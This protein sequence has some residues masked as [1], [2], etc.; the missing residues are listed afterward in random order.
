MKQKK[1]FQYGLALVIAAAVVLLLS[2]K[3]II[4]A[5]PQ[6]FGYRSKDLFGIYTA[7]LDGRGFTQILC[8]PTRELTHARFSP[9]GRRITMTRFNKLLVGGLAE[10]N[11]SGYVNTEVLV[12]NA[13][14]S[15]LRSL[16]KTGPDVMN[17]NSS[18]IDNDRLIF[19]HS[20]NIKTTLPELRIINLSTGSI[21]RVPT[22]KNSVASDP[23]TCNGLVVFPVIAL[24]NDSRV[25]NPLWLMHLDGKGLEQLTAPK[26]TATS[27]QLDFKL[28]DYDPWFAPDGKTVAFMRY[29]GGFDWRI[30]TVDTTTKKERELTLPGVGNGIPKWS[31]D[32]RLIVYVSWDHSKLENLGLYVMNAD[33]GNKRQLPLPA[34][35]LYTHPSFLP[36]SGSA[37]TARII[38]S[39]RHVPALPGSKPVN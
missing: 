29:F 19:I 27:N 20:P 1:V 31:S 7:Q 18:W 2:F 26:I 12:A 24:T 5:G 39:A 21:E 3:E 32:G 15:G 33:G 37:S 34:G 4:K 17:A 25:C 13:D 35:F 22:P 11:G 30:Y 16:V 9:D 8:D 14:G 10:E 36:A 28:G 6:F 38:F 23:T